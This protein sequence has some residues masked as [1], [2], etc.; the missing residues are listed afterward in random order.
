MLDT[1]GTAALTAAAAAAAA[2]AAVADCEAECC[3]QKFAVDAKT[4]D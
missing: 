3:P 2:A 1:Q 4:A